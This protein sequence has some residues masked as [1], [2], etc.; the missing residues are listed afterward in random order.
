MSF[1][2]SLINLPYSKPGDDLKKCLVEDSEGCVN[3]KL[4]LAKMIH[5]L[6]TSVNQLEIINNL[7]PSDN[8]LDIYGSGKNI[9]MSGDN[10]VLTILL[11]KGCVI[12]GIFE[13]EDENGIFN[14]NHSNDS[15]D[16]DD[17]DDAIH[18]VNYDDVDSDSDSGSEISV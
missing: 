7:I 15:D 10:E 17:S 5:L 16:S 2:E 13:E 1:I 8:T 14:S 9:G 18:Y 3:V 6:K 4:T 12:E 11:D